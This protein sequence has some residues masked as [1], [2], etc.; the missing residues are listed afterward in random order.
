MANAKLYD[1]SGTLKGTV[2]L[3]SSLFDAAVHRGALYDAVRQHL[4][5]TRRGTAKAKERS[6]VHYSNK[7]PW[8][9]K[10]TGRARSGRR[11]SPIWRHGGVVFPPHPRDYRYAI[12]KQVKRLA[13]ISALS[14]KGR[15]ER[16]V[17]VE[18]ASADAPK[19]ARFAEFL[20]KAELD[21]KRVLFVTGVWNDALWKSMRNIPGVEYGLGRNLN[22]YGV[23]KADTLV[24]TKE[25]LASIEEV[26]AQ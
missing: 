23:L 5:N 20:R 15:S 12:P 8:R 26:F 16:V 3:P 14:D 1:Y 25:A 24:L 2:E 19:T 17:V 6:E 18:G 21:G 7:K 9:Q 13:L 11:N 22:A 4:A 10:G